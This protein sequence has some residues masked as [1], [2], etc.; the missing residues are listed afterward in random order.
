MNTVEP[1]FEALGNQDMNSLFD[2][3]GINRYPIVSKS[4]KTKWL[5]LKNELEKRTKT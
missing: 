3:L 2:A 1:V 5:N 4:Q